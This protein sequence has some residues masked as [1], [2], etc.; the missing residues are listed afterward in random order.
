MGPPGE[1]PSEA[2]AG[3]AILSSRPVEQEG[4]GGAAI[5][6]GK[7]EIRRDARAFQT[8]SPADNPRGVSS[9]SV[10]PRRER[11]CAPGFNASPANWF[12][13]HADAPHSAGVAISAAHSGAMQR[14]LGG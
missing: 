2:L 6:T 1:A 10:G 8:A 11:R 4:F 12:T 7:T 5:V 13:E 3:P 14:G 9:P